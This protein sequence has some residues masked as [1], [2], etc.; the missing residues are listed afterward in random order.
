MQMH[1]S[2]FFR[3]CLLL[4]GAIVLSSCANIPNVSMAADPAKTAPQAGE[5]V[6][7]ISMSG[8]T[9][10]VGQLDTI[11][12]RRVILHGEQSNPNDAYILK[13]VTKGL[14]RDSAIY[15][16]VVPPGSYSIDRFDIYQGQ[17]YI[18]MSAAGQRLLGPIDIRAGIPADLGRLVITS[19]K[20]K[21]LIG[22]SKL[23]ANNVEYLKK[24]LPAH[25][26][27]FEAKTIDPGW[28]NSRDKTDVV[29]EY[30]LAQPAGLDALTELSSG[31][32]AGA[33]R[34][35]L[36]M[37]RTK[38][39]DWSTLHSGRLEALTYVKPVD[40]P[41]ATLLATGEFNTLLR[42]DRITGRLVA[43]SVGDLPLG[44]I[45]FIEGDP[46]SGWFIGHQENTKLSILHSPSLT[47]PQ[48]KE[49]R[50]EVI[51][52]SFWD[53]SNQ[54]WVWR[55][56]TGF[57][58]AVSNG[59]IYFYESG[60]RNWAT[61]TA[62]GGRRILEIRNYPGDIL[63]MMSSPGGGFGGI[64]SGLYVSRDR[65][66]TWQELESPFSIKTRA[67]VVLPSGNIL[68]AGGVFDK[69]QLQISK[70]NGK[71]WT[72]HTDKV[73]FGDSFYVLPN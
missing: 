7:V 33:S 22:R 28:R 24:Y 46:E 53:G 19:L 64:F 12:L 10:R 71:T 25:A 42:R 55:T 39:G 43:M 68:V 54:M 3:V 15:V 51:G 5:T 2:G 6:I 62:P 38:G 4:L 69:P 67:P 59:N 48:W 60:N 29:E 36:L 23:P 52:H 37:L 20:E 14:G 31:E 70:D 45:L 17:S 49:I 18:P 63:T 9:T 66:L 35:G 65:A 41:N 40:L 1:L 11:R 13:Q 56:A 57:A 21:V 30:A 47:T 58:Y 44:T 27:F 26:K 32:A 8:N 16:G 61:R 73:G 72:Q 34:L 50:T